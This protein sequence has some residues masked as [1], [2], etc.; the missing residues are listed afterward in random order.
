MN[1][2]IDNQNIKAAQSA[3]ATVSMTQEEYRNMR[4]YAWQKQVTIKATQQPDGSVEF[5]APLVFLAAAG[6]FE[7]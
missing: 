7:F 4:L 2:T 5:T 1:A 3:T 6:F